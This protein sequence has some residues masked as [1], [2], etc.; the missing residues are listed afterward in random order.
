MKI[1]TN[2]SKVA[3]CIL[4]TWFYHWYNAHQVRT[5]C[6]PRHFLQRLAFSPSTWLKSTNKNILLWELVAWCILDT[7]WYLIL[8]LIKMHTKPGLLAPLA[9]ICNV[10]LFLLPHDSTQRGILCGLLI[11]VKTYQLDDSNWSLLLLEAE[12]IYSDIYSRVLSSTRPY[13]ALINLTWTFRFKFKK[14]ILCDLLIQLAPSPEGHPRSDCVWWLTP[15]STQI[16]HSKSVEFDQH[17][18]CLTQNRLVRFQIFC[19][20]WDKFQIP[21]SAEAC[22]H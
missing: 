11:Q 6:S 7:V 1:N 19:G 16:I 5:P 13:Q 14:H 21:L 20:V 3:W 4:D 18:W 22:L 8:S 9:I 10:F 15:L 2:Q 17:L 12:N